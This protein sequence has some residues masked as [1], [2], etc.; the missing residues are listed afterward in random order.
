MEKLLSLISIL[1]FISTLS[2]YKFSF[3]LSK[4][5]EDCD[6]ESP[7]PDSYGMLLLTSRTKTQNIP[8]WSVNA[9]LA[10]PCDQM[11]TFQIKP[12]FNIHGGTVRT[13]RNI[14]SYSGAASEASV[15][16]LTDFIRLWNAGFGRSKNPVVGIDIEVNGGFAEIKYQIVNGD[17]VNQLDSLGMAYK[18]RQEDYSVKRKEKKVPQID[19]DWDINF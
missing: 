17:L 2:C 8:S 13:K 19:N 9:S 1:F 4:D 11:K 10:I 5:F 18:Y 16:D 14:T 15:V 12:S 7:S 3:K 6:S